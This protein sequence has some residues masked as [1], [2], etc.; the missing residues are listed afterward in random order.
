MPIATIC[1][2][3]YFSTNLF[4]HKLV[5]QQHF[6]LCT[7]GLGGFVLHVFNFPYKKL[8]LVL[9]VK[10]SNKLIVI[11]IIVYICDP[12]SFKFW[13]H[14]NTFSQFFNLLYHSLN[15]LPHGI[16]DGMR[17][18]ATCFIRFYKTYRNT[19][20]LLAPFLMYCILFCLLNAFSVACVSR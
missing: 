1:L 16:I 18:K 7:F 5:N 3:Y 17:Y 14:H 9:L 20:K 6:V 8:N 10:Q 12:G 4:Y 2:H 19:R 13:C 15:L 11:G